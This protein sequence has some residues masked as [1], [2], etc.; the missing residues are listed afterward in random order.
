[1]KFNLQLSENMKHMALE[2]KLYPSWQCFLSNKENWIPHVQSRAVEYS[3]PIKTK[4]KGV[5]KNVSLVR[6]TVSSVATKTCK[7]NQM[8][9]YKIFCITKTQQS[10]WVCFNKQLSRKAHV[11]CVQQHGLWRTWLFAWWKTG[12]VDLDLPVRIIC[13]FWNS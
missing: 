4:Q 10:K 8:L 2:H 5:R 6:L 9:V 1:M 12:F 13:V 7:L 11:I 3:F